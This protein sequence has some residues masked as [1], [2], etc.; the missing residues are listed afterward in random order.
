MVCRMTNQWQQKVVVI[1]GA[2]SGIGEALAYGLARRG[3]QLIIGARRRDALEGVAAACKKLGGEAVPVVT[4][5]TRPTDCRRLIQAAVDRWGRLDVLIN[6]AGIS[7]RA[8]FIETSPEVLRKVM[9]VNFW[10]TVY[11]THY[12][13]E[14]LLKQKG[15]LV[16][17]SSIAGFKGLPGRAAYSASKFAMNGLLETIRIETLHTGMHVLV[18]AP[19]FTASNIR[20]VALTASG[21]PQGET[22]LEESKLMSPAEVAEATIRGIEKR[23][24]YVILTM[25]GKLTV[26]LNKCFPGLM[27]RLVFRHMLREKDSPLQRMK[28]WWHSM[29]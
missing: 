7:M 10:G 2:S 26:W 22:P 1:T 25:Q 3:T 13:M 24:R 8:L 15:T 4:D 17:I 6:N 29:H 9:E 27:D 23:R 11:C 19:G 21:A 28:Q 18:C 20:N 5:V 16:G 12:A 14:H